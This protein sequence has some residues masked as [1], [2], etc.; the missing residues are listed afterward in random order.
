MQNIR[1]G[2]SISL[3]GR[4]SAQGKE[5]FEGLTLWIKDVNQSGG[6][7]IK[8]S[9]KKLPVNLIYYDDGS[10]VETCKIL[11]DRLIVK[12]KVDV[13]IGPYSSG[14]TLG[15]APIAEKYKKILWN[16]GGSS[17]EIFEKGF[18]YIVSTITPASRYLTGVIDMLKS[19]DGRAKKIAI[20]HAQDS[21]FSASVADG[22][23][24]HGE[25]RGFQVIEFRYKSGENNFSPLLQKVKEE[26]PDV[27]FCAGRADDDI[28][29]A[30]QMIEHW[31]SAKA[32]ALVAAAIKDFKGILGKK[33]EGFLG[34][35]QWERE[36]KITPDFGPTPEEFFKRFIETYSKEPDYPAAQG[37]NIGVIIQ[38]FIEQAGTL[39]DKN[40]REAVNKISLK[41]FYGDF[42]ID[43]ATGK[44]V[45]HK[46]VIV[47]WQSGNKVI[48]YPDEVAESDPIYPMLNT[49]PSGF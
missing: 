24:R 38:R 10:S 47:Q 49:R 7:L 2:V 28:N 21:G 36:I 45:G 12:D 22:A 20:F 11:V 23:K 43:T 33:S 39:N 48:V 40:L 30:G 6:I 29:L 3:S 1:F 9:G 41:T 37:Y 25:E 26:N 35:S 31:V 44:Q 13:L 32:I 17:D 15:A 18:T 27:I 46:M 42:K 4:Y 16:H 19:I 8:K 34:P 14:L 5:S